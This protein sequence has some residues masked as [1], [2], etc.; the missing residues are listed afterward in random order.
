MFYMKDN[1][2]S[3]GY[4][5]FRPATKLLWVKFSSSLSFSFLIYKVWIEISYV[6]VKI[7]IIL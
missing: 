5:Y 6:V 3:D 2:C 7:K 4:I 1:T